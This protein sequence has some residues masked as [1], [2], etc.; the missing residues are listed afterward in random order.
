MIAII[1]A[2]EQE[3]EAIKNRMQS[4]NEKRIAHTLF[5]EGLLEGKSV[6]LSQS[7]IGKVNASV[8]TTLLFQHYDVDYVINIG[9]AGGIKMDCNVLDIVISHQVGYHD[10]DVTGFNYSL[11]QVPG[12]PVFYESNQALIEKVKTILEQE[13]FPYH[14]GL[15]V[16]GDSFINRPDQIDVIKTNF[17]NAIAVE[18]EA[19]SIAQVC[20][21]FQK[22]FIILRS[23]SDIAGKESNI[24]FD[25]YLEKAAANSSRFIEALIK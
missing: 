21:V 10:V 20:H 19:A 23:L 3:V 18:M 6:V 17:N 1:G 16:S 9:T 4:V 2:M 7:G 24:S 5:Y 8:S 25:T 22:P 14:E 11:G 12:M 15:I 13:N